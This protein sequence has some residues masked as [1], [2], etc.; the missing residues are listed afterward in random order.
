MTLY[1]ALSSC[2]FML[3]KDD[4]VP[5]LD[6][7]VDL[8]AYYLDA[9]ANNR[10]ENSMQVGDIEVPLLDSIDNTKAKYDKFVSEL[11]ENKI[12]VTLKFL[13]NKL[14]KLIATNYLPCSEIEEIEVK[15][16]KFAN[17]SFSK[18][19]TAIKNIV[20]K[21]GKAIHKFELTKNALLISSGKYKVDYIY[22]I[23]NYDYY[24]EITDFLP[25]LTYS[26]LVDGILG[27]YYILNGFYEEAD[28]YLTRFE[29]QM[30]AINR[31]TKEVRIKERLWQ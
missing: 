25:S 3:D 23:S 30:N 29:S 1:E 26:A 9:V 13:G 6:E 20:D 21:N 7:G 15:D 16:N 27:E 2:L 24:D 22:A 31:K 17:A 12:V 5:K 8:Y 19:I 28:F 14:L 10:T 4:I 18:N 11:E